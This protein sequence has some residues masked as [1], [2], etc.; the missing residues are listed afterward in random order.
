MNK[1][2]GYSI[3]L[4]KDWIIIEDY[5]GVSMAAYKDSDNTININITVVKNN[6]DAMENVIEKSITNLKSMV[7]MGIIEDVF[8]KKNN[9][10]EWRTI[11]FHAVLNE[12]KYYS[13]M[14]YIF[15]ANAKKYHVITSICGIDKEHKCSK[16]F[17]Q[18]VNSFTLE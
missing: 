7:N 14:T 13:T 12:N 3:G 9:K 11:K 18:I 1:K 4:P 6:E 10:E 2:D 15:N 16:I 8:L 17:D 5:E